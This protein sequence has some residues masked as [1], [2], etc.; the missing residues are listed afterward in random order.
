MDSSP[1]VNK[2][3]QRVL[4][5]AQAHG[6]EAAFQG[7][8]VLIGGRILCSVVLFGQWPMADGRVS[9]QLDFFIKFEKRHLKQSL[10]GWGKDQE[11]AISVAFENFNRST[12]HIVLAAFFPEKQSDINVETWNIAGK[13]WKAYFDSIVYVCSDTET[14]QELYALPIFDTL[15]ACIEKNSYSEK[16]NWLSFF[17]NGSTLEVL[18][19]NEVWKEGLEAFQKVS[20]PQT[21]QYF[22]A[23]IFVIFI[24]E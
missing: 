21:G 19:N 18:L 16:I 4:E 8:E 2:L 3:N 5:L 13:K 9:I 24:E 14:Q 11:E 10:A 15:E 17:V 22:S 6:Y 20:W 1:E 23:R 12:L 7:E